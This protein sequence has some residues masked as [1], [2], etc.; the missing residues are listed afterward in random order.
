MLDLGKKLLKSNPGLSDVKEYMELLE[1]QRDALQRG[2]AEK[3]EWLNECL[4][5]QLFNKEAD[6]ID[7][8]TSAHQAFLEFNDLGVSIFCSKRLTK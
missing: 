5:L 2:W 3:Q 4:Q 1:A 6:N 7:A 8:A